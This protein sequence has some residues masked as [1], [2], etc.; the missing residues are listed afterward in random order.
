VR[1]HNREY[2]IDS[3]SPFIW[4]TNV[5]KIISFVTF[6]LYKPFIGAMMFALKEE[7]YESYSAWKRK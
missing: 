3:T 1:V 7:I 4:V 2:H 6:K 5:E